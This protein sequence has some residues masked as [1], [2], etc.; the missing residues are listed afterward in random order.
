MTRH[1]Y[2]HRLR[3]VVTLGGLVVAAFVASPGRASASVQYQVWYMEEA[4]SKCR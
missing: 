2:A 3:S 1:T 4:P